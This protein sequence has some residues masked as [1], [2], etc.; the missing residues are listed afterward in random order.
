MDMRPDAGIFGLRLIEVRANTGPTAD[1]GPARAYKAASTVPV[2]YKT[3]K[4]VHY[5]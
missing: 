3:C 4:T 1:S 2:S 5:G